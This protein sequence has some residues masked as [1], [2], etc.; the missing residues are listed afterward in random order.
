MPPILAE[1]KPQMRSDHPPPFATPTLSTPKRPRGYRDN[2]YSRFFLKTA[3]KT[4]ERNKEICGGI[5]KILFT[6]L[7]IKWGIQVQVAEAVTLRYIA[8]NT[9]VPVPKV[10]CAFKEEN[11][12][13]ILMDWVKGEN[14]RGRWTIAS[15]AE[16]ESCSSS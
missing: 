1:N 11:V 16:R 10:H 14:I 4:A 2:I 15:E 8:N 9:K 6:N 5:T 3:L 12:T 13:Y 7:A